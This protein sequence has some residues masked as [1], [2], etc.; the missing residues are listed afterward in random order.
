MDFHLEDAL[1]QLSVSFFLDF[2]FPS[3]SAIVLEYTAAIEF[4]PKKIKFQT[5]S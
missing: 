3:S 1:S 5:H 4:C 2:N